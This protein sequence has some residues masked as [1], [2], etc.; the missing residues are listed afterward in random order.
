MHGHELMAQKD[1]KAASEALF[2]Q[3]LAN[4][5]RRLQTASPVGKK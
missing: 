1:R 4:N 3:W 5:Q 2:G